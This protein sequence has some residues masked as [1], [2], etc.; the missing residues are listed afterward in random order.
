MAKDMV[1]NPYR[2]FYGL[3]ENHP[4]RPAVVRGDVLP[5]VHGCPLH[6]AI[7]SLE[8]LS[9]S[10]VKCDFKLPLDHDHGIERHCSMHCTVNPG[11]HGHDTRCSAPVGADAT[12]SREERAGPVVLVLVYIGFA[13]HVQREAVGGRDDADVADWYWQLSLRTQGLAGE[14]GFAIAIVS[15]DVMRHASGT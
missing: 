13:R 5:L 9:L 4:S 15:C 14:Y 7:S 8:N 11:L 2:P 3:Y 10:R 12:G 1:S 6:K